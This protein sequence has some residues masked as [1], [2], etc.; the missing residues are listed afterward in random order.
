M[1]AHC[2]HAGFHWFVSAKELPP[3]GGRGFGQVYAIHLESIVRFQLEA[4]GQKTL[5]V[6]GVFLVIV[7]CI[8]IKRVLG[9]IVLAG[10]KR[11]HTAQPE[12]ALA[13]VQDGAVKSYAQIRLQ[14]LAE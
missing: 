6:K 11:A 12:D 2:F 10:Q 1:K 8:T 5:Y 4:V 7:G 9:E 13:A 14:S 3:S